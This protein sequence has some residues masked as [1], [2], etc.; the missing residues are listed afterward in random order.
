MCVQEYLL[1][2][3]KGISVT[4][5]PKAMAWPASIQLVDQCKWFILFTQYTVHKLPL[6]TIYLLL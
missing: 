6:V 5:G 2:R 3:V 4:W 1:I